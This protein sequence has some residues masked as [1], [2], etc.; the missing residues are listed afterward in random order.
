MK[1]VWV[2]G[3]VVMGGGYEKGRGGSV[4]HR[5]RANGTV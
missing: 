2:V 4:H 5:N 3:V 1:R